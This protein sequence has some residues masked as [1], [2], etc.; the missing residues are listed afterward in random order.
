[1]GK[2]RVKPRKG[3]NCLEI[4][5]SDEK[6]SFSKLRAKYIIENQLNLNAYFP[7][8]QWNEW[9]LIDSINGNVKLSEL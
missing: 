1:M 5:N 4:S 2:R 6:F 7:Y 8:N 3:S 9:E